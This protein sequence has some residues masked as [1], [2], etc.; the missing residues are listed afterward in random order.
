M[1][2]HLSVTFPFDSVPYVI[3]S[4]ADLLFKSRRGCV[5]NQ[6]AVLCGGFLDK[7]DCSESYNTNFEHTALAQKILLYGLIN[8]SVYA[9][10]HQRFVFGR[11]TIDIVRL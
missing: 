4:S 6:C 9:K 10:N 3:S 5:E 7:C 1:Y 11:V 2:I 8:S